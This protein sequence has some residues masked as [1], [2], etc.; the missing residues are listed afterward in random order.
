M[1]HFYG[2]CTRPVSQARSIGERTAYQTRQK[3]LRRIEFDPTNTERGGRCHVVI[4][5]A[6]QETR[7]DVDRPFA[8][9][10]L[11]QARAGLATTAS[12]RER[13]DGALRMMRTIVERVD[14]G[15]MRFEAVLHA[16][17]EQFYGSFIEV[18]ACD[19]GLICNDQYVVAG[20]V[21][22]PHRFRR[23]LDPFELFGFVHKAVVH[24]QDSVAIEK[25]RPAAFAGATAFLLRH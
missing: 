20:S 11:E 4:S 14:V 19:A 13:L 22:K 3:F 12:Y 9:C 17:M 21:Q 24:I 15:T 10:L 1:P 6:D 7:I 8:R 23:S 16:G 5:V 25:C 18:T 2:S